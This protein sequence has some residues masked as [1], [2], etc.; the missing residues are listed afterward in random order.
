M[1][2]D[3]KKSKEEIEKATSIGEV[4]EAS[5]DGKSIFSEEEKGLYFINTLITDEKD[6]KEV[7]NLLLR[8][9]KAKEDKKRDD[10]L[11]ADLEAEK[12]YGTR[13]SLA[14][15]VLNSPNNLVRK[16]IDYLVFLGKVIPEDSKAKREEKINE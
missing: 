14:Y 13:G 12:E 8:I 11:V 9:K 15:R 2:I 1:A 3:L 16:T 10:K 5:V 4:K 6:A 7:A